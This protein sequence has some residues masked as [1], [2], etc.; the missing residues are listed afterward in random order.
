MHL[1]NVI[2]LD[3]YN[4]GYKDRNIIWIKVYIKMIGGSY[5]FEVLHD[6]DKWR[7]IALIM[8]QV[9]AGKPIPADKRWLSGKGM[10]LNL[11]PLNKTLEALAK[12]QL[13]ELIDVTNDTKEN[14]DALRTCNAPVTQSRVDKSREDKEGEESNT[15]QPIRYGDHVVL[16]IDALETLKKSFGHPV[17]EKYIEKIN[18]YCSAKGTKYKD[19]A[20]VIRQWVRRDKEDG[21]IIQEPID[22][23]TRK[24]NEQLKKMGLKC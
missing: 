1:I 5:E 18:D 9:Q 20:A 19:Y 7:F 21:K 13:I 8:L 10:D 23:V 2:N 4:P 16:T 14:A 22:E 12:S 3:K 6:S 24:T 17:V 15:T 11:R